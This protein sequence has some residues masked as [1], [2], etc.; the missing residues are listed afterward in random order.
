VCTTILWVFGAVLILVTAFSGLDKCPSLTGA[1]V[2][3]YLMGILSLCLGLLCCCYH[4]IRSDEDLP[5]A[6]FCVAYCLLLLFIFTSVAGTTSV[7]THYS[8]LSNGSD[9]D[10]HTHKD[11]PC[12]L[13]HLPVGVMV[14]SFVLG[15]FFVVMSYVACVLALGATSDIK[16]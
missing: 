7:F 4:W 1:S 6:L 10:I 3:C 12:G 2:F 16:W 11:V 13:T 9:Y 14:I 15:V 8:T 5:H